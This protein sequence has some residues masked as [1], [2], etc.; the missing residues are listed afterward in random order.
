[1]TNKYAEGYPSKRYYGGCEFGD[2]AEELALERV[3]KFF[4]CKGFNPN[5]V[6]WGYEDNEFP[7]RVHI[8]GYSVVRINYSE[9][10]LFH[11]P[12]DPPA[13]PSNKN[14]ENTPN[15]RECA[16]V[17]SSTKEELQEYIKTWNV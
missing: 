5:F 4:D 17:E 14:A 10:L 6:G 7:S 2:K 9:A 1:M 11:L 3:K 13:G 15:Q 8:L 12:H 16:M